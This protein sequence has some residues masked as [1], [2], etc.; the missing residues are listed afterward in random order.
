VTNGQAAAG[1]LSQRGFYEI[2]SIHTIGRNHAGVRYADWS[3][4]IECVVG[5]AEWVTTGALDPRPSTE[6][7]GEGEKRRVI[8]VDSLIGDYCIFDN[9]FASTFK[10]KN[11]L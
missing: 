5:A 2:R 6:P 1:A 4:P 11:P 8:I 9:L 3:A 7:A 10:N